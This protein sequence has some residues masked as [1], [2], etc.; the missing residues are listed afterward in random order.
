[1]EVRLSLSAPAPGEP[2]TYDTFSSFALRH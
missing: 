1:V 2:V